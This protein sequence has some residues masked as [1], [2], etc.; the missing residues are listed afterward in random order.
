MRVSGSLTFLDVGQNDIGKE[1]TLELVSSFKEKQIVS[2]TVS[3][4]N[5]N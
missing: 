3:L 2:L 4:T 5:S 1:A